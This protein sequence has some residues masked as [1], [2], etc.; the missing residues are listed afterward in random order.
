M[1]TLSALA[2]RAKRVAVLGLVLVGIGAG[3]ATAYWTAS[4]EV[5]GSAGAA[6]V[7][8]TQT[9]PLKLEKTYNAGAL[10][11][12]DAVTITNTGERAANVRTTVSASSGQALSSALH[13]RL[14]EVATAGACT[15]SAVLKDAVTGGSGL[16]Y[17]PQQKLPA[18]QSIIVCVQT[19]L[20]PQDLFSLPASSAEV[21]VT[22][23]LTY[24]PG[25]KWTTL[26]STAKVQQ[27]LA[28]DRA[29]GA[30][31]ATC[32]GDRNDIWHT[33]DMIAFGLKR[34]F[35]AGATDIR[36]FMVQNGQISELESSAITVN[37]AEDTV[38]IPEEILLTQRRG[39]G[40]TQVV[41]TQGEATGVRTIAGLGKIEFT[42]ALNWD[43]ITNATCR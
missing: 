20:T 33:K 12:A 28:S 38:V 24:A 32:S 13:I 15:P 31:G 19:S 1:K 14:S 43:W 30:P 22:S 17:A 11:A 6:S 18:G 29:S 8:I 37:L 25:A 7:G 42:S 2:V 23:T 9:K 21:S 5:H 10:T 34:G 3:A 39:L 35:S 40:P 16:I 4:D 27:G 26:P 41:I 36:A